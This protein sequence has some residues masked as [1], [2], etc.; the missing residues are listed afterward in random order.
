MA[1][2]LTLR[3]AETIIDRILTDRLSNHGFLRSELLGFDRN[4]RGICTQHIAIPVRTTAF[5]MFFMANL[6]VEIEMIK[7][8][9]SRVSVIPELQNALVCPIHFLTHDKQ[10]H[11]WSGETAVEIADAS[12]D[13]AGAIEEKGLRY[14][15]NC[16]DPD[17]VIAE[18]K[19]HPGECLFAV[20]SVSRV[21]MLSV[22]YLARG[23]IEEAERAFDEEIASG[24][25]EGPRRRPRIESVRQQLLG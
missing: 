10:F 17:W 8:A 21:A 9:F 6:A 7:R 25:H 15:K 1:S 12:H 20:E 14:F 13:L 23:K 2:G 16:E 5:T 11:E 18:L 24:R 19:S 4:V 3:Q 22:L